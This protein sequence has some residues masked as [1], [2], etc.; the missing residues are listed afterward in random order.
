M[1]LAELV[2]SLAEQMELV[3]S[4]R[5]VKLETRGDKRLT[6]HG[7]RDWLERAVLNL[8]DNAIKFTPAG[9]QVVVAL[10]REEQF[11]RLEVQDTGVGI[12]AEALPHIFERFYRADP[13]RSKSV[14]GAGLGLNLVQWI[15][16]QHHGR[17]NAA[18]SPGSGTLITL[19]LPLVSRSTVTP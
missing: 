5:E 12:S 16:D 3:A 15:V 13:S 19:W 1:D 11:A 9:G 17:V 14:E 10:G 4:A 6:V 8:L 7:D 18:S 2:D